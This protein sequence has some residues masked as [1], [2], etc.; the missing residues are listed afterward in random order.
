MS[1]CQARVVKQTK[2][3]YFPNS[4]KRFYLENQC[5]NTTSDVLCSKCENRPTVW[6]HKNDPNYSKTLHGIMEEPIPDWS[7]IEGGKWYK[8]EMLVYNTMKQAPIIEK[9]KKEVKQKTK[10]VHQPPVTIP[11]PEVK[12][13]NKLE[14]KEDVLKRISK[15]VNQLPDT[16]PLPEVKAKAKENIN[17]LHEIKAIL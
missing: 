4:K 16:I 13:E 9:P 3:E 17:P 2:F 1:R 8:Q 14:L 7:H 10:M 5:E 12:L 15:M 11:L 6:N